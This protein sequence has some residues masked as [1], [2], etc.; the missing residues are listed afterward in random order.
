MKLLNIILVFLLSFSALA[1]DVT[2]IE[3]GTPAPYSGHLFTPKKA[4]EIRKELLEKDQ[5]KIFTEALLKN[6][7]RYNKIIN[8]Q[9]EQIKILEEHTT[10]LYKIAEESQQMQTYQKVL[11][12]GLGVFAT[13]LA[14]YGAG[15]LVK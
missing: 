4:A 10:K 15:Q 2:Y 8:N 12:F 14:V 7:V 13:S 5:L 6:E 1:K 11:W 9:Q 3:A